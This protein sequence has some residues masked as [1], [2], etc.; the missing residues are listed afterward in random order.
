[1]KVCQKSHRYSNFNPRPLI[2]INEAN[3]RINSPMTIGKVRRRDHEHR[4]KIRLK[5]GTHYGCQN[6]VTSQLVPQK[7][8]ARAMYRIDTQRKYFLEVVENNFKFYS[9]I[10]RVVGID[11]DLVNPRSD[12]LQHKHK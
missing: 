5:S 2:G 11:A 12:Y 6:K 4:P 10:Y 8:L 9:F 1:M 7:R 3:A